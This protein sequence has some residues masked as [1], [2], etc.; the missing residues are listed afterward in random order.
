V[1]GRRSAGSG[2]RTPD[3]PETVLVRI[4]SDAQGDEVVITSEREYF[5]SRDY[6]NVIA[7]SDEV[8]F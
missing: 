3:P 7:T 4:V 6:K 8:D 1:R 5:F 2:S